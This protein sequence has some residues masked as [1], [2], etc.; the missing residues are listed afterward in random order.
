MNGSRENV[1]I[2]DSSQRDNPP[3]DELRELLNYRN[4]ITQLIRRD[5][6]TRYKRSFLG[7]AWT[8]LNPLGMMLV[9]T[10]AFSQIFRFATEYSYAVYVLTG[11]L[12]WN[13]FSQT[14]TA[15][16]VN[17]VWGGGLLNRI[18]IPRTSFALAAIGTG[19]VNLT[20]A[21]IPLLAVMLITRTPIRPAI[22]YLPIPM[23]L[24]AGFSL[25]LGLLISTAAVY[26]PDVAEMYQ[27][28]LMGWF[29]LTPVIYPEEILPEPIGF[30]ILHLNP[31]YYFVRLY[32]IPTYNGRL[33]TWE[34]FLPAFVISV[35][36]LLVGWW[37]FTRRSDEFAYRV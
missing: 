16:M 26:F 25:G 5:V 34:E 29:Y 22:L 31:M 32:R 8:L 1:R 10:L 28:V 17:L 20:L 33:P 24:L 23:L 14:T 9:I 12:S 36:L 35:V 6:L 13:F 21:T 27:I 30:W 2:Y 19:L 15:C 11:L 37:F 3:L 4:L 7:V 18:Y